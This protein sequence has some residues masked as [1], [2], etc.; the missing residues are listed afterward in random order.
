VTSSTRVAWDPEAYAAEGRS[1]TTKS[2]GVNTTRR[3]LTFAMAGGLIALNL[4]R[5]TL[6]GTGQGAAI[7]QLAQTLVEAQTPYREGGTDPTGFDCS[8][9]VWYTHTSV[10]LDVPR[11]AILQSQ[12]ARPVPREALEAGDLLFFKVSDQPGGSQVDH[13]GIFAD[14]GLLI[15]VSA[16]RQ[17]VSYELLEYMQSYL[18]S[19]GRFWG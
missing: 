15:H 6:A 3:H 16:H 2:S 7:V 12:A 9:L 14:F 1:G 19:T 11:T 8:G 13:V 17:A 18:V 10:G 5:P 4:P